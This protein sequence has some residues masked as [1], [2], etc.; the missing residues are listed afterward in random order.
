MIII[1]IISFIIT[2]IVILV[3]IIIVV[4]VKDPIL[5]VCTFQMYGSTPGTL[6]NRFSSSTN[7]WSLPRGGGVAFRAAY[8]IALYNYISNK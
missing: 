2:I 3:I 8:L 1:I 7:I 5:V 4:T 6:E